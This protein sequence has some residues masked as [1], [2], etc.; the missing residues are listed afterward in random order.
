M[1]SFRRALLFGLGSAILVGVTSWA[2]G[3]SVILPGMLVGLV[4]TFFGIYLTDKE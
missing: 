1:R 3:L 2:I 4:L